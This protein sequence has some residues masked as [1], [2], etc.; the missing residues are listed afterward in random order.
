MKRSGGDTGKRVTVRLSGDDLAN[1]PSGSPVSQS[2]RRALEKLREDDADRAWRSDVSRRLSAIEMSLDRA[3]VSHNADILTTL[4]ALETGPRV[5]RIETFLLLIA[6]AQARFLEHYGGL[7]AS[8]ERMARSGYS[9]G[10]RDIDGNADS[11]WS[12]TR[13]HILEQIFDP[14]DVQ[15]QAMAHAISTPGAATA[16]CAGESREPAVAPCDRTDRAAE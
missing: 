1:L 5:V 11:R 6:E 16:S 4:D 7:H 13:D 15:L 10:E 2:I 3:L 9:A 12:A 14:F 8:V